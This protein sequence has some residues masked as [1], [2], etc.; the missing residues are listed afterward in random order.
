MNVFPA[1]DLYLQCAYIEDSDVCTITCTFC[2]DLFLIL[3]E[4]SRLKTEQDLL[5]WIR[6]PVLSSRK[7]I[8]YSIQWEYDMK[9][10]KDLE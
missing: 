3:H 1:T 9:V 8:S 7:F 6:S 10:L 5:T 2:Q 4:I